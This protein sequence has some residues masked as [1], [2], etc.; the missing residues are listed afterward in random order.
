MDILFALL[1]L[2]Y[3]YMGDKANY[4]LKYHLLGRRAEIYTDTNDYILSRI[5]WATLL[6]WVTIPLAFLHKI[7]LNRG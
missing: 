6:G 5:I 2:I 1:M 7:F 3:C 4:Y